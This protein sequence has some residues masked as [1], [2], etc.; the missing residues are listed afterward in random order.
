MDDEYM[1]DNIFFPIVIV[2][3]LLAVALVCAAVG[4]ADWQRC[5]DLEMA[6]WGPHYWSVSSGCMAVVGGA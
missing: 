6:G 5:Q 3:F 2:G 1:P 4:W